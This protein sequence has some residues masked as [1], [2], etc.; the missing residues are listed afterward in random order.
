MKP[1]D[2]PSSL[3]LTITETLTRMDSVKDDINNFDFS[4]KIRQIIENYKSLIS[5]IFS[6]E[7]RSYEDKEK[8]NK[9]LKSLSITEIGA[10]NYFQRN[11]NEMELVYE[12]IIKIKK[13]I[14]LSKAHDGDVINKAL[15]VEIL[16]RTRDEVVLLI[17]DFNKLS[18]NI[19]NAIQK[20][21]ITTTSFGYRNNVKLYNLNTIITKILTITNP[22]TTISAEFRKLTDETMLTN[23][24]IVGKR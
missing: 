7:P 3:C 12:K 14:C 8:Y 18:G 19:N 6:M 24:I 15:F 16:T 9:I 23:K 21:P 11:L 13:S 20:L 4:N 10:I 5:V 2:I 1:T 17:L 22:N